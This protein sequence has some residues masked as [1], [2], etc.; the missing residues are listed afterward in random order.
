M[1]DRFFK[2]PRTLNGADTVTPEDTRLVFKWRLVRNPKEK[3]DNA[4]QFEVVFSP[5]KMVSGGAADY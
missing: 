2:F 1:P 3:I 4:Q 5:N